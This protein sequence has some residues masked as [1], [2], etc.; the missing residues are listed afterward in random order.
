MD[1]RLTP[2]NARAALDTLRGTVEAPRFTPGE[3]ARVTVPLVDL[4]RAPQGPRERQLLLGDALTVIDRH[5]GWAFVQ[6]SKDGYC[7]YLPEAAV[8]PPQAPTHWISAPASHLYPEPRVRARERAAL[9]FGAQLTVTATSGTFAETPEGFVPLAHLRPADAPLSDPVAVATLFLGAPYLWGGNSRAGIDCS[10]LVQAALLACGI[11]CPGDSDLQESVGQE[12][13]EGADLR[14]GDLLFWKGHVALVADS[15]RILH[16]TGHF[17][18]TVF[19]DRIA[20]I[21]RIAA[22]GQPVIARRR[23]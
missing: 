9:P 23:P 10:G 5:E 14:A 7:G 19:E 13:P 6:A 8:G 12:L 20:A 21:D 2:A 11:A 22:A 15:T 4:C 16:A 18:A 17:M 3:A 1:R